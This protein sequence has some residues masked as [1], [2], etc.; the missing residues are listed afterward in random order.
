VWN[1]QRTDRDL[2]DPAN[3]SMG[4]R[5]V[6][7]WNLPDGWVISNRPAH[8][9]LVSEADFVA[10]QDVC[11]ARGP[12]PGAG[13]GLPD[14]RRY[15]LSGLL[16]CGTCGRRMESA[17]SNGKPAYR[18]RHGHATA[19]APDPD[20][21]KNAHVRED[22]ILPHLPALHAL[23]TQAP[24]GEGRRPAHPPRH[25]PARLARLARKRTLAISPDW[26][27]ADAFL[28]CWQRLCALPAPT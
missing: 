1:R 8:E 17:W 27:W 14:K 21:P 4:H 2:A 11:A 5:S 18:C 12:S 10:A 6:Q 28:T 25:L 26:P 24:P 20:R 9:A 19:S 3:V 7:R 13:P 23:I 22:R 16:T 15:L